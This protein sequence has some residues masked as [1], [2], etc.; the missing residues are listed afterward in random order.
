MTDHLK[1]FKTVNEIITKI[2]DSILE[3]YNTKFYFISLVVY[4]IK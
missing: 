4:K 2:Y 1:Y 3:V